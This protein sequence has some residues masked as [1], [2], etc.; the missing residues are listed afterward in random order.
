MSTTPGLLIA[1][2][3]L[4][5]CVQAGNVH[6][7]SEGPEPRAAFS[8]VLVSQLSSEDDEDGTGAVPVESFDERAR[9]VLGESSPGAALPH[10]TLDQEVLYKFLL[11]EI[12]GQRGNYQLAAQG[13]Y[14]LAK[15]TRDP[16][17]ARRATEAAQYAKMGALALD[18]ARLWYELD[19]N[20]KPARQALTNALIGSNKL[21]EAKPHLQQL[22]SGES[23]PAMA[24]LQLNNALAR[25]QDKAAVL[26]LVQEVA[27][28]YAQAPEA[29]FAV[30]Q[31][32]VGAGKFDLAAGE[33][34]EALRIKPDWEAA[35]L[36]KAQL[37]QQR[38]SPEKS[39]E[40]LA[41]AVRKYPKAKEL[42]LYYA[43][44]LVNTKQ[45]AQAREQYEQLITEVPNNADL[46]V[47]AGLIS[48]QLDDFRGAEAHLTRALDMNYRDPEAIKYYLGQSFEEQKRY[49]EAMNWY[50]EVAGGDQ[51]IQAQSRYAALLAKQNKLPQAREHLQQLKT[52]DD[53]QKVQLVQAEAQLL[54]EAKAYQEA[55]DVLKKGLDGKPDNLDM[56]YDLAMV[57]ERLDK[58]D[59]LESSLMRVIQIKPD[60]AQA[61]NALG[62]TLADRNLR[63]TEAKQFLDK[64]LKLSPDDGF[65][66]DSM[67]WLLYRMGKNQE[68]LTYLERA[69]KHRPDP[70]IAAHLGEVLLKLG[71]RDEAQKLW[72]DSLREHPENEVLGET[73]RRLMPSGT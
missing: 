22:I 15:S 10:R 17:L 64:A 72:K 16:R 23:N 21:Q 42:R 50:R 11:S 71:R 63:L 27:K 53:E 52:H 65:I 5:G 39:A 24:L 33:I 1:V 13:Y 54:R 3:L 18:A 38:E 47:T 36:F 44:A 14:D 20:S 69:Y 68:A 34:S 29:H 56:L 48:L 35:H 73:V 70:E 28:D 43:R 25:H 7:S 62:Y 60:H 26:S 61:Y 12:A 9:R 49:D 58:L 46:V 31:A 4:S 40:Y 45:L 55:F 41:E 2:V 51:Y 67:G 37:I 59:V 8:E 66:L 30:A 19:K 6:F 57:A 32:A